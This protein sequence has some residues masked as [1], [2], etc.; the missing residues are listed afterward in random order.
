MKD[1]RSAS[2]PV[3]ASSG[4]GD[5]KVIS[6]IEPETNFALVRS[7]MSCASQRLKSRL[8]AAGRAWYCAIFWDQS[9]N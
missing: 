4:Y 6:K 2:A 1:W 9:P 5:V 7:L 3:L 8:S